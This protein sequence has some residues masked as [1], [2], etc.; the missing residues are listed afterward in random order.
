MSLAHT[1][2][3]YLFVD[4]LFLHILGVANN[5]AMNKNEHIPGDPSFNLQRDIPK[6]VLVDEMV[7]LLLIFREMNIVFS[8]T[9]V[10]TS[11]SFY[12]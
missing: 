9:P 10:H 12:F 4:K 6:R 2:L 8:I 11:P 1:V 5:T 3:T 7:S